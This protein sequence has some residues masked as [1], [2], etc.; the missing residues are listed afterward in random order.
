MTPRLGLLLLTPIALIGC[1][2]PQAP[3]IQSL[4]PVAGQAGTVAPR[5]DG[6]HRQ[7]PGVR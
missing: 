7:R 3:V 2:L 6:P 5:V 4:P 1:E